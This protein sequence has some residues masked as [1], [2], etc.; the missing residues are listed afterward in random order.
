MPISR[1]T[2]VCVN[3]PVAGLEPDWKCRILKYMLSYTSIFTS[4]L[5]KCESTFA[6]SLWVSASILF[7]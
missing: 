3:M 5:E 6:V 7:W 2:V 1:Y 4:N